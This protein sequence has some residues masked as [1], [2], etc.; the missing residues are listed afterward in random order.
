MSLIY[1]FFK[2]ST[3]M[4]AELSYK[5]EQGYI[6]P[7]IS[8]TVWVCMMCPRSKR[9]FVL[10]GRMLSGC[11]TQIT[12]GCY[13][14]SLAFPVLVFELIVAEISLRPGKHFSLSHN[15]PCACKTAVLLELRE[16]HRAVLD[17]AEFGKEKRP[18]EE[19]KIE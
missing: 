17:K 8:L 12:K 18:E 13:L 4:G 6:M 3:V 15:K 7:C 14:L 19:K 11:N 1:L 10:E 2:H 9:R 16:S 5:E